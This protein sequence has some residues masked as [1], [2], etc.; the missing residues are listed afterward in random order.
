MSVDWIGHHFFLLLIRACIYLSCLCH[1][2]WIVPVTLVCVPGHESIL[3]SL[4]LLRTREVN[5]SSLPPS[6]RLIMYSM[7]L[8]VTEVP[9]DKCICIMDRGGGQSV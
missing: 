8:F 6:L 4:P 3:G 7:W 5:W 1:T 2:F 9:A